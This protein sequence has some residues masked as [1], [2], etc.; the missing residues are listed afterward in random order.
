MVREV[1][2]AAFSKPVHF[3]VDDDPDLLRHDVTHD[4][5]RDA[6][7][8]PVPT[9]GFFTT[10]IKNAADKYDGRTINGLAISTHPK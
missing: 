10:T 4:C 5:L 7:G 2:W 6:S 1:C 9:L 8:R 3:T